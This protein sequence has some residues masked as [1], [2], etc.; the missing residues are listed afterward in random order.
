MEGGMS[1]DELEARLSAQRRVLRWLLL[2]V[3]ASEADYQDLV[4]SL[5]E[6][7]PPQ[8]G[9]EDPG[10]VPTEAFAGFAASAAEIRAILEPVKAR[11]GSETL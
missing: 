11:H 8:D 9:Q 10:A 1:A 7:F 2:K 6:S 3:V 5:D 4:A